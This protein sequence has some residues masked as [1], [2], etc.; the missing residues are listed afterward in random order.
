M[1][2]SFSIELQFFICFAFFIQWSCAK[3]ENK[4]EDNSISKSYK[5]VK[6]KEKYLTFPIRSSGQISLKQEVL[7]SFKIGGNIKQVFVEKGDKVRKGQILATLDKSI[8]QEQYRQAEENYKRIKEDLERLEELLKK[9]NIGTSQ[10][11]RELNTSLKIA[12]S[13]KSIANKNLQEANLIAPNSGIILEK[14]KNIGEII[15]P[16][17]PIFQMS[18]QNSGFIFK[19]GL[20]DNQVVKVDIGNRVEIKLSAFLNKKIEGEVTTIA[21]IPNRITGLYEIEVKFNQ[22]NLELKSGFI[23]EALIYAKAKKKYQIIPP[24][25]LIEANKQEGKIYTFSKKTNKIIEKEVTIAYI[26]D[27]AIAIQSGLEKVREVLIP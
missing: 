13:R 25:A 11:I 14:F 18:N 4:K 12:Q 24:Q 9:E 23:G 27:D 19:I 10:R 26:L 1:F 5:K 22:A 8:I 6:V 3:K 7:L 20:S 16:S 17:Q 2:K 15:A 21:T